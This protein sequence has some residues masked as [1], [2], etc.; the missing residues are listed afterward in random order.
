V[1]VAWIGG[2]DGV[3]TGIDLRGGRTAP[4]HG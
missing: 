1:F 2:F 4:A 3:G